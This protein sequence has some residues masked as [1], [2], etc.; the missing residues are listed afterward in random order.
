MA[1]LVCDLI[2][3]DF[4]P[5]IFERKKGK[6]E[7]FST[8]YVNRSR[9]HWGQATPVRW[10]QVN[11]PTSQLYGSSVELPLAVAKGILSTMALFWVARITGDIYGSL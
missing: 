2:Y 1:I 6:V 10:A 8:I 5:E 4:Y 11:T 9:P 7:L 3:F